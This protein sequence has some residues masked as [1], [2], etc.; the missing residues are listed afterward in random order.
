MIESNWAKRFD[1]N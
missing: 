1:R